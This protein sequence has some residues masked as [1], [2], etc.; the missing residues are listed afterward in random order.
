MIKNWK[1][2]LKQ[3]TASHGDSHSLHLLGSMIVPPPKPND[4][5][6][7]QGVGY[8]KF[9][10][11]KRVTFNEAQSICA[12]ECGHLAIINSDEESNVLKIIYD[13]YVTSGGDLA[14]IGFY[15]RNEA[16]GFR[17]FVTIFGQPLNETG[18]MRWRGNDPNNGGGIEFCGCVFPDGLIGDVSCEVK[19]S[20]F[21]EYDLSWHHPLPL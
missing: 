11:S 17:E 9:H 10:H 21:C 14:F 2:N 20:F 1:V 12:K 13:R 19:A 6:L 15:D 4:Y 5:E 3:R 8:Y 16:Q 18:F 7:F